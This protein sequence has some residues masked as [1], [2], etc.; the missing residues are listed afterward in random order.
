MDIRQAPLGWAQKQQ[1]VV[2]ILVFLK[3]TD[4]EQSVIIPR[5][6]NHQI[7]SMAKAQFPFHFPY[8]FPIN[9]RG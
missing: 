5:L 4:H 1:F 9:S 8:S 2:A 3:R 7:K 6:L